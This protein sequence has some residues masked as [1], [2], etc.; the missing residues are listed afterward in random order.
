MN[1]QQ[2][3]ILAQEGN[4]SAIA[5]LLS[6]ILHKRQITTK[7]VKQVQKL[8]I[9]LEA[10]NLPSPETTKSLIR[11]FLLHINLESITIVKIYGKKKGKSDPIWIESLHLTQAPLSNPL[12]LDTANVISEDGKD[13][14]LITANGG[15][16]T[17]T[18]NKIKYNP[19]TTIFVSLLSTISIAAG[20]NWKSINQSLAD[21]S[22]TPT[23]N[24][25]PETPPSNPNSADLLPK[26][27]LPAISPPEIFAPSSTITETASLTI[28]AVGDIIP[29]TNYPHNRLPQQ[30][31]QLFAS[32]KGYL[33]GTD[34]L[35]GNFESTLTNHPYPA[36]DTSRPNVFAFRT[37]PEYAK[38]LQE[39][40][41]DVLSVANNHSLDFHHTGF[42]DTM[43][44]IE[45]VGMKAV[46]DKNQILYLEQN[47]L[48]IAFIGFSNY[49]YHNSMNDLK[50]A[51]KLVKEADQTADII[52]ISVHGGAEGT[53]ALRVKNETEYFY[54][55]NRGNQVLFAHTMIDAG[56]DLILG[57]GPHVPRAIELYQGKLIAYSLGNFVG[58]RS[59]STAAQLAYSLILQAEMDSQGNFVKGKIIPVHLNNEGIP[60]IDQ[61]FRSVEL[62]RNLTESDFPDTPLLINRKGEILMQK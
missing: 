26:P 20:Y 1:Q 21:N 9:L 31:Q 23:P 48:K 50:T 49:D 43:K 8:H 14:N 4:P 58:Y 55:E 10:D 46:G 19:K 5:Y 38:L 22:L 15:I 28:K 35:F 27:Q 61:Y 3:R 30:K 42:N 44:H 2:I 12:P 53:S 62:I 57:H 45:T 40:G 56:A 60:Q 34:L 36:K 6:K 51:A 54:G 17:K 18:T 16:Q 11:R 47:N 59:L 39:V 13:S 7:V 33:Q 41:F 37:P 32:V 29:G 25:P 24:N 52:I